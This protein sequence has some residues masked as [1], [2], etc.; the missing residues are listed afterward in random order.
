MKCQ[1]RIA[2]GNLNRFV[3]RMRRNETTYVTCPYQTEIYER[4]HDSICRNSHRVH[5]FSG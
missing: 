5:C 2:G 1:F 4:C 3:S